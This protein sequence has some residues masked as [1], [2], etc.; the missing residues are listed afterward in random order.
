[1]AKIFNGIKE[2]INARIN[3]P[4]F[5]ENIKTVFINSYSYNQYFYD[6][7]YNNNMEYDVDP[8]VLIFKRIQ[9]KEKFFLF[10]FNFNK[11]PKL[12]HIQSEDV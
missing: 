1:M 2:I 5:T 10:I 12:I 9:E 6:D 7:E 3:C 4:S 8:G 11:Y